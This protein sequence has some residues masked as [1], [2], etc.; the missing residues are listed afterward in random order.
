MCRRLLLTGCVLCLAA[1]AVAPAQSGVDDG[2]VAYFK[3][4]ETSGT[5]AADSSGRGNDGT[6]IG[7]NVAWVEG[8]D[9]GALAINAPATGDVA[10]RLE[11]PT[12]GMSP[13]AGTI[14]IW[15]YLADPQPASSGRYIFGHTSNGTGRAFADRLQIYMQDGSNVS[16]KIDL[17]LGG[18][19]TTKADIVELPM[20]QWVHLALTWNNGAYVLYIDGESVA[21]GSYSGLTTF[22][23]IANFGN[24]G[25]GDPYEAFSGML[26]E[27]RVY[28]RAITA[29]EVKTI[30]RMLPSSKIMAKKPAPAHGTTNVPP[31]AALAWTA[32]EFAA[33]H[34]VY[35]GTTFDDVNNASRGN[36]GSVLVSRGQADTAF[37]PEG[38]LAYGQT[39]YWRIDEVNA[40]PDSTIYK[41]TVW[42]FTTEPYGFAIPNVTAT[43]SS[44]QAGMGPENTVNG[45]GLNADDQHDTNL[46]TMWM[47][48]GGKPAWIE[49]EFDKVYKLHELWVWNSNQLIEPLIGFGAK[50]VAIEYSIDGETWIALEGVP[51]FAQASGGPAYTPNT[52]VNLGGVTARFVK[53]TIET[54]WGGMPQTGLSEVRFLYVPVQAFD[55]QPADG[56]AGVSVETDLVWHPGREATS[57]T[58]FIDADRNAVAEGTVSGKA[59]QGSV[60]TPP[61]LNFATTYFWRVDE[62]GDTGAYAGDVWTFATEAFAAIDDFESYND[63]VAA[64]T[65]I[66]HAWIDGV[67]D[68]ASGSQVGYDESPFAEKTILHGG[69]QSM[70]MRYDNSTSPFYSQAQRTFDTPQNWTAHGGDALRLH[71]R[72]VAP[73]FA[74][75]ADGSILMNGIGADIW[76]TSDAFRFA[77]KS[78][79]GNG[80]L[81]ARVDSL[82]NSNTWAKAGVM[83]RQNVQPGSVHAF[84]AK[85]AVDGNGASFQR[86]PTAGAESANNDSPTPVAFPYWVKIQR[87]GNSFTAYTSPDGAAWTQLGDAL[88]LT[89]TDPVLIGLA[90]CSHDAAVGTAAEF[91]NVSFNGNVAGGWQ[92]A[93]IGLAQTEGNSAEP[94]YVTVTDASGKS[95]TVMSSDRLASGRLTWQEWRIALSEFASAGVKMTAVK[96][97]AIGVGDKAAP[98]AGGT[99]IVYIDDVGF[100]HPAQ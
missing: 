48:P 59:T 51:E 28:N 39:Y 88:T 21:N 85:T 41:G 54:N 52:I 71:F 87:T 95:K 99:G 73:S 69:K 35:L 14:S 56:A 81:V 60:Y 42:S 83:I 24:D 64:E 74:E 82:Y 19:H 11:F 6:V 13:A 45:S 31:D 26:D 40:A 29:T 36:P 9:G 70:P 27:A 5:T 72:G 57:H 15:L 63:D 16:R 3:L 50:D 4:D 77:Y 47:T 49:Y 7:T 25:C 2:L 76:G 17:G 98:K 33:T 66:W 12:A 78:L 79:S 37:D 80:S 44:S 92:M 86:R 100:G 93:E 75:T 91:S 84:M 97:L 43:A 32:S 89:M 10:D 46:M 18:A 67:T 20:S 38:L 23:S 62:A 8:R 96:S 61:S 94:L 30:F 90:V 34:D 65:T 68:Q 58:V 55:P 22:R 1:A 53:L